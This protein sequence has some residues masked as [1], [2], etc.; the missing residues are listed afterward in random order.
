M[1][2]GNQFDAFQE[3]GRKATSSDLSLLRSAT[4]G[5]SDTYFKALPSSQVQ[6]RSAAQASASGQFD[7]TGAIE[8]LGLNEEQ[9]RRTEKYGHQRCLVK[10][11]LLHQ[12]NLNKKKKGIYQKHN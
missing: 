3:K 2:K 11:D 1:G 6:Q 5:L 12:N 8:S 9:R 4:D 7:V 10:V